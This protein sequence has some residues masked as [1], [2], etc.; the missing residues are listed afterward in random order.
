[1]R[2]STTTSRR[3]LIVADNQDT[4]RSLAFLFESWGHEVKIVPDGPSAVAA[5]IAFRPEAILLDIALPL[6]DGFA[7]AEQIR[8]LPGLNR[9]LLIGTSGYNRDSDFRRAARVGIDVYLVKPFDP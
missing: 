4:A 7:V 3:V 1:M 6:M 5:A 2:G 9:V 8:L